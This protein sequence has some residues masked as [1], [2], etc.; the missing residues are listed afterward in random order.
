MPKRKQQ[1]KKTHTAG[2]KTWPNIYL[3]WR[4]ENCL[5][6]KLTGMQ[7]GCLRPYNCSNLVGT[8]INKQIRKQ[9]RLGTGNNYN[10]SAFQ[11]AQTSLL[12][13]LYAVLQ[14]CS[15]SNWGSDIEFEWESGACTSVTRPLNK[16][17]LNFS[18]LL[19]TTRWK[20]P[21]ERDNKAIFTWGWP[22]NISYFHTTSKRWVSQDYI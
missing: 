7:K 22:G 19:L 4:T 18:R 13:A 3:V 1:N 8:K 16:C 12:S 2:N 9:W 14:L 6:D 15:S 5:R 11:K 17:L 21:S 20:T 10:D